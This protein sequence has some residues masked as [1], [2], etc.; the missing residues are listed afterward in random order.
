MEKLKEVIHIECGGVAYLCEDR[1]YQTFEPTNHKWFYHTDKNPCIPYEEIR[2]GF[3]DKRITLVVKDD[4]SLEA[5]DTV[6]F[7]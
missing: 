3:C 4:N 7:F 1:E 2:C 6:D 5:K